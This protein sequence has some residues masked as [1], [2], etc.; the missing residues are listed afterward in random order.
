MMTKKVRKSDEEMLWEELS[1]RSVI[2]NTD[3]SKS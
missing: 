1:I 3:I 2:K